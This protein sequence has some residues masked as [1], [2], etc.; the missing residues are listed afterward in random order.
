MRGTHSPQCGS[1]FLCIRVD[2]STQTFPACCDRGRHVRRC[3]LHTRPR[4]L[5]IASPGSHG[6]THSGSC[7]IHPFL[8]TQSQQTRMDLDD[9]LERS[10]RMCLEGRNICTHIHAACLSTAFHWDTYDPHIRPHRVRSDCPPAPE[11]RHTQSP[12]APVH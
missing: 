12:G 4:L 7:P 6:G 1:V 5:R 8:G 3:E 10:F 11:G 9:S 2:S